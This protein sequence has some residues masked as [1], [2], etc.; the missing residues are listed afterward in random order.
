MYMNVKTIRR[1]TGGKEQ[2]FTQSFPR[3]RK[4]KEYSEELKDQIRT[5][6]SNGR[7]INYIQTKYKVGRNIVIQL[8]N[9]L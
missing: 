9:E 1:V 5:D 6:L 7:G 2:I 8:K 3:F 4:K